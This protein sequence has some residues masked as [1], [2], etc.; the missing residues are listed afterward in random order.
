MVRIHYVSGRWTV[1]FPHVSLAGYAWRIDRRIYQGR[2]ILSTHPHGSMI[3]RINNDRYRV[4]SRAL[5]EARQAGF[6]QLCVNDADGC[7]RDNDGAV[8]VKI[9]VTDN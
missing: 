5:I 9:S 7:L 2:K 8:R 1:D 3:A 6:L 4:G